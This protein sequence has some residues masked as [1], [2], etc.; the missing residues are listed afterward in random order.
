M[1]KYFHLK[2]K[3]ILNSL[4]TNWILIIMISWFFYHA[5]VHAKPLSFIYITIDQWFPTSEPWYMWVPCGYQQVYHWELSHF[6]MSNGG[7]ICFW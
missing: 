7:R 4:V 5:I 3:K 1:S 6:K 2:A